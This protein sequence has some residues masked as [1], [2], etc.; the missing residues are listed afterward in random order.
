MKKIFV[1]IS[2]LTICFIMTACEKEK[3]ECGCPYCKENGIECSEGC[4]FEN[5][6]CSCEGCP[7]KK[8]DVAP[9]DPVTV[10]TRE[11]NLVKQLTHVNMN[12]QRPEIEGMSDLI[13][14][15][16][17]NQEISDS[18]TPYWDE[19]NNLSEG[20]SAE[21]DDMIKS[22]SYKYNVTYDVYR[23]DNYLCL[24]VNHD[25]RTGNYA[26]TY[27][28]PEKTDGL[29]SSQWRETYVIDTQNNK[30]LTFADVCDIPNCKY[31]VREE[32]NNQ[33]SQNGIE[34]VLGSG[35]FEI[36]DNQRFYINNKTKKLI[37]YFEPGTIAK[38]SAGELLF[39]M[40]FTYSDSTKK[41]TR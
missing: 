25:I 27:D 31:I 6:V 36:P 5:N 39:E 23:L 1:L 33:A 35:V 24:V 9:E 40:P 17:I 22:K 28:D 32:V 15:Q 21:A 20:F 8:I 16:T 19:I 3:Y 10:V 11:R 18:I 34:L 38:Y 14:Q 37:I 12:V 41:F 13:L 29:R 4:H 30:R 26:G 7:A 2:V